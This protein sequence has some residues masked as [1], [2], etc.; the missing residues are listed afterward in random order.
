MTADE[1]LETGYGPSASSGDNLVN[2]FQRGTAR[3][4]AALSRARGDR[5]H[6]IEGLL[7][8]ADSQSV[9]PF[10]NRAVLEQPTDDVDRVVRELRSF[11]AAGTGG[12]FLL[13]S[14]WPTP[15][16]RAHELE[17]M[18]HPPLMVRPPNAPLPP[19]PAELRIVEVTD[20]VDNIA[21]LAEVRGRGYGT[22]ITAATIAVDLTK[23]ATLVA[24]D[25]GRPI[26]EGL[27][28]VAITRATYWIGM[29]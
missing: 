4:F 9:I 15:D 2:D 3:S 24:S 10:E 17:L 18:G 20:D 21:T 16:L 27:R 1:P 8:L 11:Y 19:A 7:T 29:R 5:T 12:P 26:Y 25:L 6:R 14:A 13:D 28:F 22:A 23:P